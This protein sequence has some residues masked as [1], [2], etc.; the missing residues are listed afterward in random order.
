MLFF[1]RNRWVL[2]KRG[3]PLILVRSG[4]IREQEA[5]FTNLGGSPE[6][7]SGIQ[8]QREDMLGVLTRAFS[9][10]LLEWSND[11]KAAS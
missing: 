11:G 4:L 7:E 6:E 10:L 2:H 5:V 8:L 3:N 1:K 9:L